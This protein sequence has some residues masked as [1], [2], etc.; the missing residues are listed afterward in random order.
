[1][2]WMKNLTATNVAQGVFLVFAGLRGA[3]AFALARNAASGHRRTI[4]PATTAVIVFTT[5][6]LGGLTRPLL[7]WLRMIRT[8]PVATEVPTRRE[9]GGAIGRKW[10]RLDAL[11]FQPLFGATSAGLADQETAGAPEDDGHV[12]MQPLSARGDGG[13]FADS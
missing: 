4:V 13:A 12:E 7:Y 11:F 6:V 8:G 5:F 9:D 3:I 10:E 1:M 2:A